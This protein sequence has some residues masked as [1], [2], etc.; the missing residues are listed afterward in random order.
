MRNKLN[1]L[2]RRIKL[3]KIKEFKKIDGFLSENEALGLFDLSK[4]LSQNS[5]ILEIGSWKGKS[6]LCLAK[7]LKKGIVYII[8]PFNADGESESKNIYLNTI[9]KLSLEEQFK[10]NLE[11]SNLFKKIKVC[12]GYS[13]EFVDLDV[14][15]SLIFIDGDHSIEGCE[16]DFLNFNEK[17]LKSGYLVFHDYYPERLQLGPTHVINKHILNNKNWQA[18]NI[19]DSLFIARKI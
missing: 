19:I 7:G 11:R 4:S 8:D 17:L 9:G 10:S 14:Q 13:A 3:N 2:I 16:F 1:N 12:K 18:V 6:T 15:F 5:N